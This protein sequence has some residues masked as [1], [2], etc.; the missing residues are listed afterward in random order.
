MDKPK[1]VIGCLHGCCQTIEIIKLYLTNMLSIAEKENKKAGYDK[2]TFHFLEADHPHDDGGKTWYSKMLNV[3]DIKVGIPYDPTYVLPTLKKVDEFVKKYNINVLLGF[4]QGGNVVD[5][6]VRYME[7]DISS[8]IIISGYSFV[9]PE[10][11]PVNV[12]FIDVFSDEDDVVP[13]DMHP[14]NYVADRITIIKHE[15][16]HRIPGN[17]VIRKI[18]SLI[19]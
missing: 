19:Q 18:L 1:F 4:S 11:K 3:D 14:T 17:P 7:N 5:S 8:V 15:K 2:F 16:G 9:D 12:N 6:Y 10:S 13:S